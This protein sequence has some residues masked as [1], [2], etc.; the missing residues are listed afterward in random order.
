MV[1]MIFHDPAK[2]GEGSAVDARHEFLVQGVD[3]SACTARIHTFLE[4][5][6]LVRYGQVEV[7]E[8]ASLTGRDPAFAARLEEALS[9]NR[10]RIRAFLE[11]LRGEGV[12]NLRQLETLP[13]GYQSK[14]LH[15]V[16]HLVDGFFGI[17][18]FFYNLVEG[19]HGVSEDLMGRMAADP[20]G[21]RLISLKASA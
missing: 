18:S 15:T 12:E 6:Q 5:Y 17:D 3:L 16:T 14:T 20:V 4:E 10:R 13:Q 21:Y 9:E 11:E 19:S 1:E 8:S 7:I 2:S